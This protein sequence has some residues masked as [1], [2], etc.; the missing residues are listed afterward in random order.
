[1]VVIKFG[2]SCISSKDNLETLVSIVKSSLDENPV[3]IV[4]APSG[5]TARLKEISYEL[6][7]KK[8]SR[9]DELNERNQVTTVYYNEIF[10]KY[11]SLA[12]EVDLEFKEVELGMEFYGS[13]MST[14][15]PDTFLRVRDSILSIGERLSARLIAQLLSNN[16]LESKAYDAYN[17]GLIT[18]SNYGNAHFNL[19]SLKPISMGI[20]NLRGVPVITGFIGKDKDGN[21]TT[22]GANSSDYS[23]VIFAVASEDTE[24]KTY[25]TVD[26]IL[27]ADSKL[28]ENPKTVT[29]LSYN[30]A[31]ELAG[32]GA[33]VITA[34]SVKLA[35]A[36]NITIVVLN[37][38]NPD[39]NFTVI[40]KESDNKSSIKVITSKNN[41]HLMNVS[42]AEMV[43]EPGH[44]AR[45]YEILGRYKIPVDMISTSETG[46]SSSFDLF[47]KD[48]K[49]MDEKIDL[50]RLEAELKTEYEVEVED[51]KAIISL[52]GENASNN[53][54]ILSRVFGVLSREKINVEMLSHR[55]KSCNLTLLAPQEYERQIVR[56]LHKEFFE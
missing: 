36:Y 45:I 51:G 30:E 12:K 28:V 10:S 29:G 19:S 47:M 5:I 35:A 14:I 43:D 31:S 23:A 55:R 50:S 2:G 53:S 40:S 20:K 54:E 9:A 48:R 32:F 46:I 8:Y 15:S 22:L 56:A 1:M 44:A 39:K 26:G 3:L 33:D 11:I 17:L 24:V 42:S 21:I 7:T 18:D 49:R 16:G 34:R 4:S 41:T 37:L 6:S 13:L 25:K 52:I 38:N 27:T